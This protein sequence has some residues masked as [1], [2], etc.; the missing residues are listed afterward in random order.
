[1]IEIPDAALVALAAI[2]P[3]YFVARRVRALL[4]SAARAEWADAAVVDTICA[5]APTAAPNAVRF[6]PR[7]HRGEARGLDLSLLSVE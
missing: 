6:Q 2:L 3:V 1:M 5:L 7:S 4:A